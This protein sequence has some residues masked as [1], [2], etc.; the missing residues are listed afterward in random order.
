MSWRSMR[1]NN[2]E[3]A[4]VR[5]SKGELTTWRGFTK[6]YRVWNIVEE[7]IKVTIDHSAPVSVGLPTP[8]TPGD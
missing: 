1:E 4:I 6:D 8:T 2:F 7:F 5:D 3:R